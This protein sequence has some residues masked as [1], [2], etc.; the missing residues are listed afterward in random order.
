AFEYDRF[1]G[2]FEK[3]LRRAGRLCLTLHSKIRL[4][5]RGQSEIVY[6]L[7]HPPAHIAD[8]RLARLYHFVRESST[9]D[10]VRREYSLAIMLEL[11][12]K[13]SVEE[14]C[15]QFCGGYEL[16]FILGSE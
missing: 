12:G 6:L 3:L 8:R 4:K 11:F 15:Q 10:D 1:I 14:F 13:P 16:L 7:H 9:C 2:D 5:P